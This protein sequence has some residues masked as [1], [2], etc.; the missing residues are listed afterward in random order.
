MAYSLE[1]IFHTIPPEFK[2]LVL[3]IS[4]VFIGFISRHCYHPWH[5]C[6]RVIDYKTH[7]KQKVTKLVAY[8]IF[9]FPY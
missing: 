4:K 5:L 9:E 1:Q 7:K 6:Q 3:W 2:R 8:V